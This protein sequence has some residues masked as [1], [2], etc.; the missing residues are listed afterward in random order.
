MYFIGRR[1]QIY[2]GCCRNFELIKLKRK[3]LMFIY[4]SDMHGLQYVELFLSNRK[5]WMKRVDKGKVEA[6]LRSVL[7]QS[8]RPHLQLTL[9]LSTMRQPL[10]ALPAT[11]SACL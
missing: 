9:I 6:D 5:G 3:D 8:R 10:Q 7:S 1:Q 2:I 4:E 11:R